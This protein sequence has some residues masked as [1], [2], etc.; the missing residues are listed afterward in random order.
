[1]ESEFFNVPADCEIVTQ[2]VIAVAPAAVFTRGQTPT[3][4][5]NGGG[6]LALPIHS[7]NLTLGLVAN[8]GLQ[9]TVLKEEITRTNAYFLK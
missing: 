2:R 3:C 4:C 7:T 1:M 5:R 9:C 8:G 6:R